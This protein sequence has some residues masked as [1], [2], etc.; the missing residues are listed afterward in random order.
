MS[1][2]PSK[3]TG[4]SAKIAAGIKATTLFLAPLMVTSPFNGRFPL[5]T[6]FFIYIL[7]YL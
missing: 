1:G 4:E 7:T 3:V 6:I 5:I 2:T